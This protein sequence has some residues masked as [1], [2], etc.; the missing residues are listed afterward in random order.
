[1]KE[2][3]VVGGGDLIGTFPTGFQVAVENYKLGSQFFYRLL[4]KVVS[5]LRQGQVIH[6]I[7]AN[8]GS[9]KLCQGRRSRA[10]SAPNLPAA[11]RSV[12]LT[13]NL[14]SS[15]ETLLHSALRSA[16]L[17][18]LRPSG[19]LVDF[20]IPFPHCGVPSSDRHQSI[21]SEASGSHESGSK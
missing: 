17:S 1:M 2:L 15:A 21:N 8:K 7:F 9:A 12:L 11:T 4:D 10:P 13:S 5:L 20:L 6:L 19:G 16:A 3:V 18:F 14:I